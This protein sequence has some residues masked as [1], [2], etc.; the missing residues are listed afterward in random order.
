MNPWRSLGLDLRLL[1]ARGLTREGRGG[2]GY[3]SEGAQ[4]GQPL[5]VGEAQLHQAET[6]DDA[7][8]D[9]PA[10]L[11]VE[12]GVHGHQLGKHF[13][14]KDPGEHLVV[15]PDQADKGSTTMTTTPRFGAIALC[16]LIL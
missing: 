13:H 9:V 1:E 11:E 16:S 3:Q 7:V 14:C 5:H 2:V 12:V 10:L 15:G 4:D 8:K 6:H